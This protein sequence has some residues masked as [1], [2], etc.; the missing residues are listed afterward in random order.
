MILSSSTQ[1]LIRVDEVKSFID[2]NIEHL[3]WNDLLFLKKNTDFTNLWKWVLYDWHSSIFGRRSLSDRFGLARDVTR[4]QI[5]G[6]TEKKRDMAGLRILLELF[7]Y[8]RG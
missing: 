2:L 6:V 4:R 8:Q 7:T 3:L 1:G 5:F